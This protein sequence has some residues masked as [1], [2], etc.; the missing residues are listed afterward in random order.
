MIGTLKDR[1]KYVMGLDLRY[2][3]G[4]FGENLGLLGIAI[5]VLRAFLRVGWERINTMRIGGAGIVLLMV[6][7][8]LIWLGKRYDKRSW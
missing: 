2:P 6:C 4:L 3:I 8:V 1:V 5:V 7:L